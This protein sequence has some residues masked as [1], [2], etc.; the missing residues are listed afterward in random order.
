MGLLGAVVLDHLARFLG[1]WI[2]RVGTLVSNALHEARNALGST[3]GRFLMAPSHISREALT[4]H[5]KAFECLTTF[6]CGHLWRLVAWKTKHFAHSW[7]NSNTYGLDG[8]QILT[9]TDNGDISLRNR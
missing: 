8:T 2:F 1:I 5:A 6:S 9:H 4:T 3:R 7:V